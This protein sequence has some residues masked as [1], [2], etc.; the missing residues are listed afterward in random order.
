MSSALK[1]PVVPVRGIDWEQVKASLPISS[2]ALIMARL[3]NCEEEKLAYAH[4]VFH[5]VDTV[6]CM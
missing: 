1:Q 3:S 4:F 6:C 2:H 5:F